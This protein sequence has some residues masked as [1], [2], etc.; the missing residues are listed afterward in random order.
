MDELCG[1]KC[2]WKR[3]LG[4]LKGELVETLNDTV[5]G[6]KEEIRSVDKR[7]TNEQSKTTG[8]FLSIADDLGQIKGALKVKTEINQRKQRISEKMIFL[9]LGAFASGIVAL[10]V[11]LIIKF[12]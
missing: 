12:S 11:H 4:A 2:E 3:E 6:V 1:D 7:L 10:A 8:R 9:L 5:N